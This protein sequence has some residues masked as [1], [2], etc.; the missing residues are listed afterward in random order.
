MYSQTVH[1]SKQLYIHCIDQLDLRQ[2]LMPRQHVFMYMMP[3]M[4]TQAQQVPEISC[5]R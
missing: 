4:G 1:L 3:T 5:S 2:R